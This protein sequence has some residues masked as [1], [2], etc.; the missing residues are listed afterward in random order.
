MVATCGIAIIIRIRDRFECS[1]SVYFL[2]LIEKWGNYCWY[3][4]F[5][6]YTDSIFYGREGTAVYSIS[7]F[8]HLNTFLRILKSH[9]CRRFQFNIQHTMIVHILNIM[10]ANFLNEFQNTSI[11]L[12]I[13]L[14]FSHYKGQIII[15][16]DSFKKIMVIPI[17]SSTRKISVT[18]L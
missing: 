14:H 5:C 10:F 6:G 17:I 4:H 16:L 11:F 8:Q 13:S 7:K 15:C 3:S 9:H 18:T 2:I 1:S 12:C